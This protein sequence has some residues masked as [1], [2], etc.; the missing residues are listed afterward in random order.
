MEIDDKENKK[1]LKVTFHFDFIKDSSIKHLIEEI[2]KMIEIQ[3]T[4][5]NIHF[6]YE[7]QGKTDN[8]KYKKCAGIGLAMEL[9]LCT[10]NI[11]FFCHSNNYD[12]IENHS[13]E[14]LSELKSKENIS[15]I[16]LGSNKF[17]AELAGKLISFLR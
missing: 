10:E 2:L 7:L 9:S 11:V 16:F 4:E 5:K 1:G 8:E 17:M 15:L 13:P 6:V 12:F 3:K 14:Q